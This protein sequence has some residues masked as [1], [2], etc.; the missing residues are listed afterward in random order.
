LAERIGI[1]RAMNN[2][3]A[4]AQ[5]YTVRIQG[6]LSGTMNLDGV[7]QVTLNVPLNVAVEGVKENLSLPDLN[8]LVEQVAERVNPGLD[9]TYGPVILSIEKQEA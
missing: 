5:G 9:F 7:G 4:A 8:K 3:I 6:R 2:D 1:I